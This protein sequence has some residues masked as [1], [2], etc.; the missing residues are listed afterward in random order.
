MSAFHPAMV[1]GC[2]KRSR[3]FGLMLP[4]DSWSKH[5]DTEGEKLNTKYNYYMFHICN[6]YVQLI[7]NNC[8]LCLCETMKNL[9][10]CRFNNYVLDTILSTYIILS[11]SYFI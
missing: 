8:N 2:M 4:M 1:V 9:S 6:I 7:I 11:I 5:N 3:A 10:D